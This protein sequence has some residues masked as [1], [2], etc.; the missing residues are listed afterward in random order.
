[1]C[2]RPIAPARLKALPDVETCIDC[3]RANDVPKIRRFDERVGEETV[4]T[5]F[6][7]NPYIEEQIEELMR[8]PLPQHTLALTAGLEEEDVVED[9]VLL[10]MAVEEVIDIEDEEN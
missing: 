2:G 6:T 4:E 1:V 9:P 8:I 7:H 10:E 3:A 5:Y